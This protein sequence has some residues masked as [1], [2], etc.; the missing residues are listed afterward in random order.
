MIPI[1]RALVLALFAV[2]AVILACR[3]EECQSMY[4]LILAFVAV[5]ATTFLPEEAFLLQMVLA[6][7]IFLMLTLLTHV[8]A[9]RTHECEKE[10]DD[11]RNKRNI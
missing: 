9:L 4:R 10:K 5:G 2:F 6:V 8:M 3:R 11:T 7:L 1:L